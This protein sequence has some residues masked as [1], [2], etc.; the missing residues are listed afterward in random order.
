MSASYQ[1]SCPF[2]FS[3]LLLFMKKYGFSFP[4]F[5]H[6]LSPHHSISLLDT[7]VV[8]FINLYASILTLPIPSLHNHENFQ[9]IYLAC[10][11]PSILLFAV[12]RLLNTVREN[13]PLCE[14]VP[15]I[16]SPDGFSAELSNS[17]SS[18]WFCSLSNF[19]YMPF[20]N[21]TNNF[22]LL[23][24]NYIPHFLIIFFFN[25]FSFSSW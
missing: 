5:S 19:S 1:I 16:W 9:I 12:P 3:C 11:Q 23:I 24:H 18:P 22:M 4:L 6:S 2:G 20:L 14:L 8:C 15:T 25:F 13:K 7:L 17:F 21:K 10:V